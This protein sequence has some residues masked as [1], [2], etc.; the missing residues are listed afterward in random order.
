MLND[1]N[2]ES[3]LNLKLKINAYTQKYSP[4]D[5]TYFGSY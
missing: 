4:F 1:Y 2:M 3:K 5:C